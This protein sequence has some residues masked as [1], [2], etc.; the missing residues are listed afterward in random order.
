MPSELPPSPKGPSLA[1]EQPPS[2][3]PIFTLVQERSD[4][5]SAEIALIFP[6]GYTDTLSLERAY[7]NEEDKL[8][9][10]DYYYYK[11]KLAGDPKACVT[12]TG[13][14]GS[15]AVEFTI[16]SDHLADSR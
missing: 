5:G 13:R 2:E 11:G 3:A 7:D 8:N 6:N 1:Q 4:D 15:E 12:A 16:L 10:A 9:G 14:V